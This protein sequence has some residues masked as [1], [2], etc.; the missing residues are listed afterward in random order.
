MF[1]KL[2]DHLKPLIYVVF[3]DARY[4]DGVSVSKIFWETCFI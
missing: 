2:S 1:V 4:I 3:F